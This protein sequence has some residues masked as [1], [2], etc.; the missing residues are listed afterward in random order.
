MF[1]DE[2]LREKQMAL[3]KDLDSPS[4]RKLVKRLVTRIV[5]GIAFFA[6][7]LKVFADEELKGKPCDFPTARVSPK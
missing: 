4:S 6:L 1:N 3:V 5:Q 7:G 2:F